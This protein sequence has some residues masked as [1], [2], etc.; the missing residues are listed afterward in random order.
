MIIAE[1]KPIPELIEMLEPYDKILV[2]GC[3]GCV[4]VCSAGGKKE[5]E[6]MASALKL[7]FGKLNVKKEI[8]EQTVPRQCESEFVQQ[9]SDNI[10]S[11]GAVLSLACGVGVEFLAERHPNTFVAP[12]LNTKFMGAVEAS[13]VWLER[14]A[15]CGD[16]LLGKTGGL[17]P[18]VRCAKGIVNGPCSGVRDDGKCEAR[19][20]ED[21]VWLKICDRLRARQALPTLLEIAPPKDWSKSFSGR[22]RRM[23][24]EDLTA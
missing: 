5:V 6:I 18:I 9:L 2:A 15:G 17:C 11:V 14:C 23:V 22:P 19:P 12:G 13:G 20:A 21:C 4:A 7:A 1:R 24:R 3:G 16:C 10:K 8:I